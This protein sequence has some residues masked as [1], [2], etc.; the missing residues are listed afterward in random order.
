MPALCRGHAAGGAAGARAGRHADASETAG[1]AWELAAL[2]QLAA[3]WGTLLQAARA[4]APA[5][6]ETDADLARQRAMVQFIYRH[7]A[8]KL[9]LADIAAA[10]GVC[11]SKCCAL[12]ARYAQQPPIEYLNRYRLEVSLRYAAPR[13]RF[14]YRGGAGLRFFQPGLLCPAVRPA[15]RL[16][17]RAWRAACKP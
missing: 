11:R 8:E 1:P 16:H 9:T 13:R 3:A 17:P 6:G 15:L 7:Y 10:G 12:F 14:R 5:A 4:A 2:G